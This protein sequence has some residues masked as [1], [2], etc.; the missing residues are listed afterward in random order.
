M[1]EEITGMVADGHI[2]LTWMGSDFNEASR[3]GYS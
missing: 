2:G 3:N 1:T